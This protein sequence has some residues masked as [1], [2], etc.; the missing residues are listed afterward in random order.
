MQKSAQPAAFTVRGHMV[1]FIYPQQA[2]AERFRSQLF[3][4]EA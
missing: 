2:A 1:K 3:K 4:R